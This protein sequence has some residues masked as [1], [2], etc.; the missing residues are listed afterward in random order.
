MTYNVLRRILNSAQSVIQTVRLVQ[1]NDAFNQTL[2]T[3]TRKHARPTTIL[4]RLTAN[5]LALYVRR[6]AADFIDASDIVVRIH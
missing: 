2:S 3:Y 1:W 4:V 5:T 6:F